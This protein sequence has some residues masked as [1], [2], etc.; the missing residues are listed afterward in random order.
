MKNTSHS[1][2]H[3]L[4][5]EHHRASSRANIDFSKQQAEKGAN[6]EKQPYFQAV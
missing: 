4:N 3:A 5:T 6:K 2:F 1:L